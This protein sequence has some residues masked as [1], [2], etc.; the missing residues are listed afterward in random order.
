MTIYKTVIALLIASTLTACV[1]HPSLEHPDYLV[2]EYEPLAVP[3]TE[4]RGSSL[5]SPYTEVALFED[6]KGYR[7]GD[8][9]N[10]LLAERTSAQKSSGTNVSKSNEATIE[11]P[12][13]GGEQ[14]DTLGS[15]RGYDW[16]FGFGLSSD[17]SFTGASGSNQSNT[18]SGSIAVTVVEE[19][20]RGNLLVQGEKWI[21]LNEGHE[22]IRVRG[23]IRRSDIAQNNTVL[24]TQI[25]DARIAYGGSGVTKDANRMGWLSRFFNSA[26]QPF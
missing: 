15:F 13:L 4:E 23:I 8:I 19:L 10:V 26:V 11:N 3:A 2:P 6:V 25:A 24:S 18:L 12:T 21:S 22:F 5:Y 9:I 14:R 17:Q 16:N 20:P 1:S 7:R